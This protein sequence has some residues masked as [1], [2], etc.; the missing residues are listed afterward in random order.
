MTTSE[1]PKAYEPQAVEERWYPYWM[2]NGL[3]ASKDRDD[4]KSF[5][6]M[7]PPPNVT[8][9]LHMG[10]GL[11]M[12]LQDVIVRT[13]RMQGYNTSWVP[14]MDHAGIA[15]QNVVERQL[16]EQGIDRRDL[17]REAFIKKV[18][19]W[20]EKSGGMIV[21]QLKKLGASCDWERERF[22]MD[23][24][25]S[26]AVRKVFVELY[27]QGWIYRDKRLVN[28][29]PKLQTAISDLEVIQKESKGKFWKFKYP[30]AGAEGQFITIA[31]TRP[32]TL[33]G[34][35]AVAVHPEDERYK[36]LVGKQLELPIVGRLIPV[37]ADEYSDPEKGT[38]AVKITPAHDF[39]DFEVGKRH[40]LDVINILDAEAKLNENVPE[41][42]QGLSREKARD[43]VVA[44][45]EALGLLAG[46]DDVVNQVPYGDRSNVVI[47]PWLTDQWFVDAEKLAG[48]A[49]DAVKKGKTTFY[50]KNWEKTYFD[51]LE[52]I[53]PW[54]ISRQI[55]WGHQVPAWFGPD[56]EIFVAETAA[57]AKEQAR[58]HYGDERELIQETD[59]LDTWFSSALWPFST[60]GWPDKTPAL[61]TFYPTGTLVTGFDIIFF[62]VARMMMMGKRF[63]GDVPFK[64]IYIHALVRDPHGQ[65]MSKSKGNV[66]DPLELMD[67]FGTDAFRF[68]LASLAA[69]GRDI[70]MSEDRVE[71]YRHFCN[72]LWNAARFFFMHVEQ[73]DAVDW[74]EEVPAKSL[75]LADKWILNKFQKVTRTVSEALEVY[76]FDQAAK[77]LYKFVWNEFC[78]WYLEA[79]KGH[80]SGKPE[81]RAACLHTFAKVF[82]G[83]LRLLHPFMPFITEEIWQKLQDTTQGAAAEGEVRS[84]VVAEWPE[85]TKRA[86]HVKDAERF[87]LIA[88]IVSAVRTIRSEN[89]VSP[90]K[91][92]PV[93][94][95]TTDD[96][97]QKLLGTYSGYIRELAKL[98]R[99]EM[100]I[101][102]VTEGPL[103]AAV[104]EGIEVYV[105]LD[106]LI[107]I[108]AEQERLTKEIAKAEKNLAGIKGKLS[109]ASFVDRAP[110]DVVQT[111]REQQERVEGELE[112]LQEVLGRLTAA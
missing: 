37:V 23:E 52:N 81:E 63:M 95:R 59:V 78:D 102:P 19:E 29:D 35:T 27:K 58:A 51:W 71:G 8:G 41:S 104:V 79:S 11:N 26:V 90:A 82:D 70:R 6:L 46:I 57:E 83:C 107:D 87:D 48:P 61:K 34:D 31:T 74:N 100:R 3:F 45:M 76:A 2:D 62:W 4:R 12:T 92:I 108:A 43:K 28:W 110:A 112:K 84:I 106:G 111:V 96:A 1:L 40:N 20:K 10:H 50:P 91:K 60:L 64:H 98:Q 67:R 69:Q 99:L 75:S 89:T 93:I 17:G 85:F 105:P 88:G 21:G 33:L 66:V 25:L 36:D 103:A 30:V 72:K 9:S 32:E 53:Q 73:G 38:G 56:G 15:T 22:T 101:T 24:G 16:A 97:T 14:G 13:K 77:A 80:L 68:T 39:N 94:L 5:A 18:W 86:V 55:W 47:E 49:L 65:K 109:N 7:I 54:C 44:E 42:Y